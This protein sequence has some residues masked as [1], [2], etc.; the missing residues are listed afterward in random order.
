[1]TLNWV[2][3]ED[4]IRAAVLTSTGLAAGKV[5]WGD[6]DDNPPTKPFVKIRL[7]DLNPVGLPSLNWDFTGSSTSTPT[8]PATPG[9]EIA[10]RSESQNELPV[11]IQVFTEATVGGTTART[12]AAKLKGDL[13]LPT[14]RN[15]LNAAGLGV[16]N[17][18]SVRWVPA[19][20]NANFEGRAVLDVL[21]SLCAT[22]SEKTGYI[23]TYQATATVSE[24]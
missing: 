9:E 15:A 5:L 14:I 17:V 6:Q 8:G 12:I 3:I 11:E 21:F 4:A 2:A 13:G 16:L 19:V 10:F 24:G 22:A 1:M 7:G 23:A 18:G 20:R